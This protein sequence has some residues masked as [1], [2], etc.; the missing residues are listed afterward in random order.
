MEK[1]RLITSETKYKELDHNSQK[2]LVKPYATL[3]DKRIILN[4]LLESDNG[5]SVEKLLENKAALMLSILDIM[6]NIDIE[7]VDLEYLVVSGLWDKVKSSIS[8]FA[9]IY[10]EYKELRDSVS[11]PTRLNNIF[12]K[13]EKFIGS[14]QG[15]DFSNESI[16][17]SLADL[18]SGLSQLGTVYPQVKSEKTP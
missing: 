5:D 8:N 1:I 14:L 10:G 7:K 6:T 11:L 9:E 16:Q 15:I 2:I 3:T 12:E 18:S 13:V 17:K 4:A